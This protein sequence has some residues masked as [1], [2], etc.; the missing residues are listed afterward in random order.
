MAE[1]LAGHPA[2]A[3][4]RYPGLTGDPGHALARRQMDLPGTMVTFDLAAGLEAGDRFAEALELFAIAARLGSTESLVLVPS[5]QQPRGFS[6][7]QRAWTDIG[8]G[9]V[10]L[11]IGVEDP[12]DL[13]EDLGRALE[14]LGGDEGS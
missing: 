6:D 9:T 2:V 1:F 8:P 4:V 12:A 7:E 11:S 14:R 13:I 3:R 10:R 5:M